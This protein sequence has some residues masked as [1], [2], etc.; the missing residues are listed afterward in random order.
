MT[1]LSLLLLLS[2]NRLHA[3]HMA[4][5]KILQQQDFTDTT[6][7]LENF[8]SFLQTVK[9]PTYLLTDLIEE[10]FRHEIVPHLTGGNRTALLKRKFDQFYRGTPF[11][12]ATIL[13]RQKTGRRDVDMLFSALT[14]P[15]IITPWLN[16]IL[17]Q[18]TPLAGIYSV[19]QISA[20]LVK[21][22]PSNHLLLISWERYSGLRQTYFSSHH[23]QISRLTPVHAD[24]T[25]EDAVIKELARTYQYL[26]SLSLLPAG[27]IL[28]VRI[29]C[30]ADDRKALRKELP[31]DADMHYDFADI[32]EVG[33][34]L[35]IDHHFTD[36]DASQI[37]LHQLVASRPKSSYA[38]TTHTRYHTLWHLRLALNWSAAMLLLA[39]ALWA[40]ATVWQ[41]GGY[42]TET[43]NLTLQ[44]QRID[45]EARQITQSFPVTHAPAVDMRAGVSIM[46]K[47][48][49]YEPIPQI[50]LKPISTALDR[51]PQIELN[52]LGWQGNAAE[53]VASNTRADVPAQVITMTGDLQGFDNDYRTALAYL[54]RFQ[55]ELSTR[56]YQVTALTKPLDVSPSGSLA[57]Q[58]KAREN[59]LGFSLKLVWRPPT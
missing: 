30:H 9:C 15:S 7:G 10:D 5:G 6:D 21:N 26:K 20:P 19:P 58:R 11:H 51:F 43:E 17:A 54:D 39:S 2:A 31:D 23:L 27:Q 28:D 16:I 32:A 59:A 38:S 34:Q 36:S 48:D 41:S 13:Q 8:A 33:K 55:L 37:F 56:G 52:E 14:N 49:Q 12:Q 53:P 3:Q 1:K 29:L 45:K 57:D 24:L 42:A 46:R 40:T 22:H 25:F 47:L 35:N 44:A 50:I 18:K 4:G